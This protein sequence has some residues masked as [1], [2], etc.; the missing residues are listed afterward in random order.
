MM[1]ADLIDIV[2]TRAV[3]H[4]K[5]V[6]LT[7]AD[8]SISYKDLNLAIHNLAH[9]LQ[10]LS[11]TC[12]GID[13][14]NSPLWILTD[15]ACIAANITTVPLPPFFTQKQREHALQ[16]SGAQHLLTDF[17]TKSENVV[18]I[19]GIGNIQICDLPYAPVDLPENCAKITYTSG[20]TGQAK[21]VCLS[22]QGMEQV[23]QS[24]VKVVGCAPAKK[25]V[26]ILPVGVL[27]ENI[28]G[29]YATLLAGGTYDIRSQAEI[30][31]AVG[32]PPDFLKLG[33]YLLEEKATG[34]IMVPELLRG[35]M[36]V[37]SSGA[38]TLADMQFIAVGGSK[39]S[40][41]LLSLAAHLKLPVF[42][43]YGLSEAG[44]VVAL[45]TKNGQQL[46]SVGQVL[47][48][49]NVKISDEG[50]IHILN[51]AFLG[52]VGKIKTSAPDVNLGFPTGD[53]GQLDKNNFL[54]VTG[55]KKNVLITSLGRNI[56]PEW[57]ESELLARAEIAQVVVAGDAEPFLCALI[58][59][60]HADYSA[61]QIQNAVDQANANLPEYAQIKAW[62]LVPPFSVQNEMLTGTARP[63]RTRI[64]ANYSALISNIYRPTN[65]ENPT[66]SN[67][68]RTQNMKFFDRLVKETEAERASLHAVPQIKE[69]L[70]GEITREAYIAYL[71]QA[72]QHVKHT[73]PLMMAAGSRLPD[74][75]EFIREALVE[76]VEEEV[77]HQ[78]WILNDIAATGGDAEAARN[79]EPND[80]TDLMVS[81][82]YDF[83]TRKNPVGFFGMV[84]VLE[85]TSTQ[86]AT[87]ASETLKNALGLTAKSF[88]YLHSHGALDL[89]HMSFFE[90]LMNQID[91]EDDQQAIIKMAKRMYILFG[92]VFRSIPNTYQK[93]A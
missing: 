87:G 8:H 76:Y 56:S 3:Q 78:E 40:P 36:Q 20:T 19:K 45:N 69:A 27:L 10:N 23:A 39:I 50:E 46:E 66:L 22:Q 13:M 86:L 17:V 74:S 73:V 1:T 30:G 24:L 80:A 77:G 57:P 90:K 75:K 88:T 38:F 79:A 11:G 72:Y 65:N 41:K 14:Q 28:A 21:G 55:R 54:Y 61:A 58:V 49:V 5:S 70:Q 67:K 62:K 32:S 26:A 53:L 91:D 51:P 82:A 48:H 71:E 42:Q 18:G 85:G 52:Y 59:P 44:S 81:Y 63:I 35:L 83:V 60:S 37:M 64:L 84:F 15:L 12:V 68:K 2:Q 89:E 7:S 33:Q 47:P 16:T 4:P 29:V 31:L 9:Q 25:T 92:N 34:S 43:G 6:A 93:A